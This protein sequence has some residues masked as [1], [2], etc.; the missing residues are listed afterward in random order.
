MVGNNWEEV[1]SRDKLERFRWTHIAGSYNIDDGLLCIYIDGELVRCNRTKIEINPEFDEVKLETAGEKELLIGFNNEMMQATN[2][3]REWT[4]PMISGFDG[5][6]DEVKIFPEPLS[7]DQI[8]KS[9]ELYK[10]DVNPTD[11]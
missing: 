1:V 10:P 8:K 3:H 9:Y 6:I 5:L 4:Y 7:W 2:A 11:T